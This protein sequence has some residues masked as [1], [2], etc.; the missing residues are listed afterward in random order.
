MNGA[1]L[2]TLD[3]FAVALDSVL[4]TAVATAKFERKK[5]YLTV[6]CDH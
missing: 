4:G 1:D 3:T 6:H 2:N 5:G